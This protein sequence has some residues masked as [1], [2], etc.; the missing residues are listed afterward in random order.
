MVD[1][2]L[3]QKTVIVAGNGRGLSPGIAH[4]FGQAGA[5]VVIAD[6]DA[7]TGEDTARALQGEGFSAAYEV[8]DLRDQSQVTA[9]V[10]RVVEDRE[11]IDVWVN[12]LS[13]ARKGAAEALTREAWQESVDTILSGTFYCSQAAGRHML[14]QGRGV[15]VNVTSVDGY[16]AIEDNAASCAAHAGL[17]MLTQALGIEWASRGV[18]VVGIAPGALT[19]DFA[20]DGANEGSDVGRAY[21]RRTPQR[22]IGA[23]EEVAEAILYLTSEEASYVTAETMRVDGGWTAYQLF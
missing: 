14:A 10:R 17:V 13:V 21:E 4:R 15:I 3:T 1:A 22:R 9:L 12:N 8:L 16:Q 20:Q 11:R 7:R 6:T 5:H 23:V 2:P 18:R 19:T